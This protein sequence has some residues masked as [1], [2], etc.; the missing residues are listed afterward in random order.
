MIVS[1][2][3]P[4]GLPHQC[5]VCGK[6]SSLD[7]SFPGSDSCCPNCGQ[8]LWWFR[9][10]LS[11]DS[12]IAP[13]K[14]TLSSSFIGDIGADSLEVV[15]LIMELEQKFDVTIPDAEA[16]RIKTVGDAIRYIEQHKKEPSARGDTG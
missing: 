11:R 13:E 5:P 2:R 9:D 7:P 15:E 1:S 4:E 14:I 12:D 10:R 16:E 3:T 6:V 8:L